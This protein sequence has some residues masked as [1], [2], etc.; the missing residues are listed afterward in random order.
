MIK[1]SDIVAVFERGKYPSVLGPNGQGTFTLRGS[2]YLGN[3]NLTNVM[4][5]ANIEIETFVLE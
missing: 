1:A 5:D 3:I 4:N 2:C